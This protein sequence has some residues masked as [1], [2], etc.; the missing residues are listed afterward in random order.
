M[1][2]RV[3]L[4]SEFYNDWGAV[5]GVCHV[6]GAVLPLNARATATLGLALERPWA[7]DACTEAD[8]QRLNV[9]LPHLQRVFLR[10]RRLGHLEAQAQ[11]EFAA[12]DTL[13]MGVIVAAADGAIMFANTAAEA[14]ARRDEGLLLGGRLS[15]LG[16]R[17]PSETQALLSCCHY[18]LP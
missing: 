12:L 17:Q 14:L 5:F 18:I 3:V 1:Q 15:G 2:Q 8:R 13:P 10:R 16:A 6:V 7:A 9:V 11:V 4:A